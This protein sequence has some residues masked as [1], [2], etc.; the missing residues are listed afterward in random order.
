MADPYLQSMTEEPIRD[1]KRASK[2]W[3]PQGKRP[4][5]KVDRSLGDMADGHA[6]RAAE[7]E[8]HERRIKT[9]LDYYATTSV[10]VERIRQHCN[11]T[12][13]EVVQGLAE[14]GRHVEASE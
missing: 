2:I 7:A 8:R 13:C 6:R 3:L 11:L 12:E 10:P 4:A 14:R 9:L 1:A 5:P